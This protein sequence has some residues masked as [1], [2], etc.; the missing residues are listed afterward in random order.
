M[1]VFFQV[2]SLQNNHDNVRLFDRRALEL[3]INYTVSYTHIPPLIC[4]KFNIK[5]GSLFVFLQIFTF[6]YSTFYAVIFILFS[7]IPHMNFCVTD[8]DIF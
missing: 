6:S 7:C 8:W 2:L 4:P 1:N 3:L 5:I